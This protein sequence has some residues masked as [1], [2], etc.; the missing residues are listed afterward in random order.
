MKLSTH[1][2]PTPI[3]YGWLYP[4]LTLYSRQSLPLGSHSPAGIYRMPIPLVVPSKSHGA[5]DEP[6]R[7]DK[8]S[9]LSL[10]LSLSLSP[11][12]TPMQS[13]GNASDRERI[14]ISILTMNTN[15][16]WGLLLAQFTS[17]SMHS[18]GEKTAYRV[19]PYLFPDHTSFMSSKVFSRIR[20]GLRTWAR[21]ADELKRTSRQQMTYT[22]SVCGALPA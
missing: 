14:L 3:V 22:P 16:R 11:K 4:F 6:L 9:S 13:M 8:S 20:V 18:P 21:L 15:G 2:N 10:S 17:F 12:P 19:F 5:A 7:N 1:P